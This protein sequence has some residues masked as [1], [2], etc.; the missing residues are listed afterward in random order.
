MRKRSKYRPKPIIGNPIAYVMKGIAVTEESRLDKLRARE[1][2]SI[3]AFARGAA[4]EPDWF[5]LYAMTDI[6]LEMARNGVGPEA[7]EACE[8]A[9]LYLMDD[10]DRFTRTGKL[11]TTGPG[12]QAY[13][14]VYEY[15]DIQRQSVP[16]KEYENH[17]RT[18]INR[19]KFSKKDGVTRT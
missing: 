9:G 8:R 3:D 2:A 19:I 4:H 15:A 7:V 16:L 10:W 13:R 11:G 14:E 12:L 17:I 18:T 1:L 6:C 5:D